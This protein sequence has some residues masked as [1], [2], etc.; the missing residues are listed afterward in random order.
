M[1]H[2]AA[3]RVGLGFRHF[4]AFPNMGRFVRSG[5]RS[6]VT[7]AA[8]HE[9]DGRVVVRFGVN[10]FPVMRP[11]QKNA[12]DYFDE[13]LRMVELADALGFEHVQTVEHY[14]SPYGGYSPDPVTFLAAAA[15]RTQRIRLVT[16][17][18]I[19]A[20]THPLKLAGKLAMLDNLSHG[21]LDV[22]FGRAFL[23]DEFAAF[24]VP[25]DQSRARFAEGVEACR[26]LWSEEDVLWE[27]E[28]HTF[29]P[30]TMSPRPVQQPHPPIF[31]ASAK[32]AES[33]A[34]AGRSGYHLQVVPSITS[35][36]GLR[37]MIGAYRAGWAESG[38]PRGG[39]RIQIKYTCY[40]S[41]DRQTALRLGETFERNYIE[42]M[43]DAIASWA[44]VRS[45]QYRGYQ[46]IVQKVRE[47]DFRKS[48]AENKVLAGT[49]AELCE[50]VATIGSWFGSDVTLSLQFN[51]GY[52]DYSNSV[53][54]MNLF[55][56]RV[57]PDF[58]ECTAPLAA[59]PR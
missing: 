4:G 45:E 25:M 54:A 48:L 19:P 14:C 8:R 2:S 13:T 57:A 10:F 28:F 58:A 30:V 47:F 44:E 42:L 37:E 7:R 3:M 41:E 22:G 33:C 32:S 59:S 17:A 50:Q 11:S 35:R 24:E 31:V 56:E 26:R 5:C 29:G 27:G 38:R 46:E 16:G 12:V 49:P 55:A 1:W 20:F 43:T 39:E 9:L 21:R 53:R 34:E 52:M 18:V 36:E 6:D 23:P 51:P 15:M 40:V